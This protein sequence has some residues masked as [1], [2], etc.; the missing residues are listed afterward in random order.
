MYYFTLRERPVKHPWGV[1]GYWGLL[2]YFILPYHSP[3]IVILHRT[4]HSLFIY[5]FSTLQIVQSSYEI[6]NFSK[7]CDQIIYF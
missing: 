4:P 6:I 2:L 7:Q 5:Y 1:V 3:A